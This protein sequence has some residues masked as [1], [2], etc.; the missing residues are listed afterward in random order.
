MP[1]FTTPCPSCGAPITVRSK[2]ALF[3]T[4]D[5]CRT[6]SMR[7]D[8][9]LENLGRISELL[10]DASPLRLGASGRVGTE[11]FE[12]VGRLQSRYGSG[13]WNEW[14][15]LFDNGSD[16]WLGEAMGLYSITSLV[17]P[18]AA[19]MASVRGPA[20]Y[21]SMEARIGEGIEIAGKEYI[22]VNAEQAQV[23]SGEGELPF[24][25]RDG[26]SAPVVDLANEQGECAT[27]DYSESSPL[28]FVGRYHDFADLRFEGL[29][30]F[31]G[32]PQ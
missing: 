16:A 23:V 20:G 13:S 7:T 31:E 25:V 8:E 32:F 18:T 2:A 15:L 10:D 19:D 14:Y 21:R 30:T 6:Q 4:C 3:V 26:Y 12:I 11:R 27:L 22:I 9:G 24:R 5:Y 1:S 17:S 29:N 28:V